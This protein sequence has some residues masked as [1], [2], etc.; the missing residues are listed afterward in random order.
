MGKRTASQA[1][2]LARAKGKS[3]ERA[4]AIDFRA[5]FPNARRTLTQQRDSGEEPDINIPGWW[6][7]AKAHKRVTIRKAFE[8]AVD[9][10]QRARSTAKPVAVTKDN[11]TEPLATLRLSD[12]IELLRQAQLGASD[13]SNAAHL[14]AVDAVLDRLAPL[15]DI[16][17]TRSDRIRG[18]QLRAWAEAAGKP[19]P[20]AVFRPAQVNDPRPTPAETPEAKRERAGL[21]T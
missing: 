20:V 17:T 14:A 2:R 9:E 10:I 16:E 8:Q 18:L 19:V 7:E 1:G 11:G 15:T 5:V 6:V 13:V 21:S 12:F 4:V 3:F